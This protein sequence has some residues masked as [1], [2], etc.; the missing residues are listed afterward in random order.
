MAEKKIRGMSKGQKK[1][2]SDQIEVFKKDYPNVELAQIMPGDDGEYKMV[3]RP[4]LATLD[5]LSIFGTEVPPDLKHKMSMT[6]STIYRDTLNRSDLDLMKPDV[7]NEAPHALY[8]KMRGYYRSKDVFGS[9]ID[10]MVNLAVAGFE[11]DCQDLKIKEFYDNWCWDIDI[12]Q[13]L[14]W[15]FQEL[16]ITGFVRTYKILGKYEPQ[17]NSLPKVANPP[18]PALPKKASGE[19]TKEFAER[20]RRWS[21]GY[22]PLGYTVLNPEQIEIKGT[23]L[24]NQDRVVLRPSPEW[25]ELIKKSETET[26]LTDL[27]KRMLDEI[28]PEVKSAVKSGNEVELDPDYVG[29]I[30]YRK[31]PW[32]KYPIPPFASTLEVVE[33]KERLREADYSTVDGITSEVL[34]VT[35][36]DKDNP[37]LDDDDLRKVAQLFNTA[38]K[39]YSVIWNHTLKVDRVEVENVDKILGAAKYEQ[40]EVDMSGSM[41]LPRA[42]VDGVVIGNTNKDSLTLSI[43]A[44][45]AELKYAR[46]QVE[47]WLQT[48]YKQI[49]EAFDF[50]M[51]P[52]IRWDEKVLKDE[53]AVMTTVQG[54]VDR[55]IISYHTAHKMLGLDS[56]YELERM[57]HEVK[58]VKDGTLGILGSP[59]QQNKGGGDSN[60]QDTQKAPKGTPSEGR[61]KNQPAPKTPK[62]SSPEGQTKEVI[63]KQV[64]E[65]KEEIR[66]GRLQRLKKMSFD[67]LADLENML[68]YAKMK[69]AEQLVN[70]LEDTEG[71]EED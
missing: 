11:N 12:Y 19:T 46:R 24:Y 59:Y 54:L 68:A 32:E 49:A 14:E 36:G 29:A 23:D 35:V 63:T 38:Q 25:E 41:G 3:F 61:P 37:V 55:R 47:R 1:G 64:K 33:Y 44:V 56:E 26:P 30:D 28:P 7:V 4:K 51:I 71:G 9:Y 45:A 42:L 43:K 21:K 57:R 40:A 58:L 60:Q 62:P 27:E 48:E 8:R 65:T 17:V 69:K 6:G 18:K 52:S 13:V 67:E 31:M 5:P 10:T 53:L 66:K 16:Y 15:I 50:P 22:V 34:V 20:K 2:V 39:A 70:L